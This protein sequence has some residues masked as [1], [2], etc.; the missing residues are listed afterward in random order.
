MQAL[1]KIGGMA[2]PAGTELW[3]DGGH[4]EGAAQVLADH[5]KGWKEADSR[6]VHL[7]V[8][9]L[10]KRAPETFLKSLL[11]YADTLTATVIPTDPSSHAPGTIADAARALGFP[12][13]RV[14][15]A[16]DA[17]QAI[18]ALAAQGPS[19]ILALGSLYLVGALLQQDR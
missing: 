10:N 14:G 18:K 15:T 4:N 8:A 13:D 12:P 6:P 3:I 1:S 7:V 2:L 9:M 5:M 17:G 16:D 19:R 11:P